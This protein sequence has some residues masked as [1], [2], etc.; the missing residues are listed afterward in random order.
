MD[1]SANVGV[2]LDGDLDVSATIVV[3]PVY[4]NVNDNNYAMTTATARCAH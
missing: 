1:V 3:D 2:G 4:V